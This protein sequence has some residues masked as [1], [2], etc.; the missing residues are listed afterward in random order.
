MILLLACT[1]G[2]RDSASFDTPF[3]GT[4]TSRILQ[5]GPLGAPPPDP[6]N[7]WADDEDAARF[8]QFVYFD[9]RFSQDGTVSCASCHLPSEGFA[10]GLAL[11]QGIGETDRH[12]P[13]VWNTAWNRWFFWDGRA[14]SHW[15]QALSPLESANEHGSNRSAYAHL[16]HDDAEMKAAYE[17]LFG[18]MP[19]ISDTDRFPLNAMPMEDA[20]DHP[21][22]QAW[23]GMDPTDQDAITQVFVNV[24]KCIAAYERQ[25]VTP[26]A[27][28]DDFVEALVNEDL[29]AMDAALSPEAQEGLG[30]FAG[31]GQ[32]HFCHAGPA[33]T[34][35]EF[36]NLG[37]GERD[38]IPLL[39][40]GRFDGTERVVASEFNGTSQWSDDPQTGSIKLDYLVIGSSEQ[41]AAFKT[42]GL[43]NVASHPPYMHGG[44]FETLEEVVHHYN[45]LEEDPAVE[46]SHRD[47]LLSELELTDE[48]EAALVTFLREALT[49]SNDLEPA[50]LEQP[51]SP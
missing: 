8:G 15:A 33:M 39:D 29:D 46:G 34:D 1:N 14:D 47:E 32:C 13:S 35:L 7:A 6:T 49:S 23:L 20:P 51:G 27:P 21:F 3:D 41:I 40:V 26:R 10:D 38:W 9:D 28:I 31:D 16:I 2:D 30:L 12:T 37:L 44:H 45:A 17:A 48:Q 42:P 19:E 4:Q 5:M 22:N 36:H 24:G 25:L 18:A 43:R 50:L 11:S